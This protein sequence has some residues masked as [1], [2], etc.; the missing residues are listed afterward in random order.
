MDKVGTK[1]H[2]YMPSSAGNARSDMLGALDIK[3]VGEIFEQIPEKFVFC[4]ISWYFVCGLLHG[5][6]QKSGLF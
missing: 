3:D 2:P 5:K 1:A 6:E 4:T